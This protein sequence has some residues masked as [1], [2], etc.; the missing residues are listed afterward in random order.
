MAAAALPRFAEFDGQVIRQWT[1]EGNDEGP[2]EYRVV[3]DDGVAR[4]GLGPDRVQR[5]LRVLAPGALVHAR[6]TLWKPRQSTV[7]LVERAA[8]ASP[9]ADLGRP[10]DP[11][12]P[13]PAVR[14]PPR[15]RPPPLTRQPQTPWTPWTSRLLSAVSAAPASS[16]IS[17]SSPN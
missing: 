12:G 7:H 17:H 16:P 3:V 6:V 11:R 5:V 13:A 14:R 2:D 15:R 10:H 9:L 8:V 1:F 4:H